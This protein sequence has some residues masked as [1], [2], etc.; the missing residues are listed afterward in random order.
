MEELH[1]LVNG[2]TSFGGSILDRF[3]NDLESEFGLPIFAFFWIVNQEIPIGA[4]V[5]VVRVYDFSC[6]GMLC[7]LLEVVAFAATV[8]LVVKVVALHVDGDEIVSLG[9]A[10]HVVH[11]IGAFLVGEQT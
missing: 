5:V 11:I 7:H 6:S 10:F 8:K 4:L 3:L 9:N 2:D 1:V